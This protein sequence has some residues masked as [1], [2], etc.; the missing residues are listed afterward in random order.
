MFL[1]SQRAVTDPSTVGW[2]TFTKQTDVFHLFVEGK[3]LLDSWGPGGVRW[4]LF[5]EQGFFLVGRGGGPSPISILIPVLPSIRAVPY[6]GPLATT[7]RWFRP[8]SVQI[9]IFSIFTKLGNSD[10]RSSSAHKYKTELQSS[11]AP[12][13]HS[14]WVRLKPQAWLSTA[15]T[16]MVSGA[17]L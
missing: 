13:I 1:L 6:E 11:S 3:T 14:L 16:A 15:Q 7:A 4:T 8:I 10:I 2:Q 5:C 9:G 17:V 12:F